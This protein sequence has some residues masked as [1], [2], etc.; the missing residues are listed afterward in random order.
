MTHEQMRIAVAEA[1]GLDVIHEAA[2]PEDRPDAWK[3]GYFTPKAASDRR[4]R[5]PSSAYVMQVPNY[6]ADLNAC[7]E[8]VAALDPSE[9]FRM[10]CEMLDILGIRD[11]QTPEPSEVFD[12]MNATALQRCEAFLKTKGLWR[13]GV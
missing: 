3:T 11:D 5:W 13:E 8:I 12:L 10:T 4:K 6:P 9:K 7:A 1:C 2:G